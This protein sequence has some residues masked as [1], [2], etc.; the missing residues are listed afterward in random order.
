MAIKTVLLAGG[1]GTLG[2]HILKAL[3]AAPFTVTVLTR[4]SSNARESLPTSVQVATVSDA[5]TVEELV[6]IV[7]GQDAVVCA[8]TT[9]SGAEED[10]LIEAASKAGGVQCL[11]PA[12]FG[13]AP[14]EPEWN[15]RVPFFGAKHARKEQLTALGVPWTAIANGGFFEWGLDS[16]FLKIDVA[17]RTA[18]MLDGGTARV[19][20]SRM[21]T[22][23]DAVVGVL[24]NPEKVRNRAIGVQSFAPTY[25]KLI[26]TIEKE[27]GGPPFEVQNHDSKTYIA[28]NE[29]NAGKGDISGIL[30][31]VWAYAMTAG[32]SEDRY[33]IFCFVHTASQTLLKLLSLCLSD[34]DL[35]SSS[36]LLL[37]IP[38]LRPASC[39]S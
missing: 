39:T 9:T 3:L 18:Q 2:S 19:G 31:L 20:L 37:P 38:S 13:A 16:G 4:A 1:T 34:L 26:A 21:S 23:A 8:L 6:P 35:S 32:P 11:I 5:Y 24:Q 33:G 30:N 22:I 12:E 36:S 27:L 28:E 15:A 10:N 7:K 17:N 29:A 25:C 14:T